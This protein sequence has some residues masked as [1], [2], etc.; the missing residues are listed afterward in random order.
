MA[1]SV[2]ILLACLRIAGLKIG[3]VNA[4]PAAILGFGLCR[5]VM[6]EGNE[7]GDIRIRQIEM[8]HTFFGTSIADNGSDLISV[9]V[10]GNQLGPSQVRPLLA[11]TSVPAVTEGASLHEK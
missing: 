11:A 7:C 4:A 8:G 10:A 2:E 9:D 5:L 1:R 3:H 6:N